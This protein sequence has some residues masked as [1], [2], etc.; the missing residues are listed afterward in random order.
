[1]KKYILPIIITLIIICTFLGFIERDTIKNNNDNAKETINYGI[2]N[3]PNDLKNMG[4]LSKRE[5]DIICAVCRGLVSK[6]QNDEIEMQIASEIKKSNDGIQYEFII[7]DDMYWSDGTK[8]TS[9]DIVEF[10]KELLREEDKETIQ[11]ILNI[12]G[13]QGFKDGTSSFEQG[14]AIKAEDNKVIIRLNKKDDGFIEEL[15]KPQYRLRKYLVLWSNIKKNYKQLTYS[16]NYKISSVDEKSIVLE[17]NKTAREDIEDI[18]I[19]KDDTVESSMAAFEVKQRDIVIDPPESELNKLAEEGKLIT[20]P[21]N[22]ATYMVINN[23]DNGIELQGRKFI[24]NTVCKAVENYQAANSNEFEPAEGSYFRSEKKD[25]T[26][27]QSRKVISNK[28]ISWDKPK[29]LTLLGQDNEENRNL[30]RVLKKWFQENEEINL[31]YSLVK[32][33]DFKDSEL[34]KRYDIVIVNNNADENN[35]QEFYFNF[36]DFLT[37][38]DKDILQKTIGNDNKEELYSNLEVS[39]FNDYRILPLIFYNENIALS[40]NISNLNMDGNE[41][42]DFGTIK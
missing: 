39:L 11:P 4:S 24:Y 40:D 2:E 5:Q 21:K 8:I 41:N 26:K 15:T 30:C 37:T 3:I 34:L 31:I 7:R 20:M 33:S 10:F 16:G 25:L 38:Q 22:D 35:K 6:N 17:K 29:I 12:Y 42:L 23:G 1:M 32:D 18:K 13:A 27:L 28:N 14:T 19:L 36:E 9:E